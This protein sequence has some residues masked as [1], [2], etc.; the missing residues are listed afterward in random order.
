LEAERQVQRRVKSA[1]LSEPTSRVRCN[2]CCAPR[3]KRKYAT[4][5]K[6]ADLQQT[7][8]K[9][10]KQTNCSNILQNKGLEHL[11]KKNQ[12]S[13]NRLAYFYL[14]CKG[15]DFFP[16]SFYK[17]TSYPSLQYK[18][19]HFTLVKHRKQIVHKINSLRL[20]TYFFAVSSL[21]PTVTNNCYFS[22]II[23]QYYFTNIY[24]LLF[25]V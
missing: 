10:D 15:I 8:A 11:Q 3:L 13:Y 6:N 9:Q 22:F 18:F 19:Y 7:F 5:T 14:S 24:L 23:F 4:Q 25:I 20:S 17:L 12:V 16:Y 21:F 1:S 2:V